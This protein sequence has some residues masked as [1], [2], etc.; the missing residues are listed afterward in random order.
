MF[1][2]T[3]QTQYGIWGAATHLSLINYTHFLSVMTG[4]GSICIYIYIYTHKQHNISQFIHTQQ[5]HIIWNTTLSFVPVC[6]LFLYWTNLLFQK[7]RNQFVWHI[8]TTYQVSVDT[9]SLISN[10]KSQITLMSVYV[11]MHGICSG[12]AKNKNLLYSQCLKAQC[13]QSLDTNTTAAPAVMWKARRSFSWDKTTPRL[14]HSLSRSP[15][16]SCLAHPLVA[17]QRS[18]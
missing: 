12:G 10:T 18:S 16:R 2:D 3:R 17:K 1:T 6:V 7:V 5:H 9:I 8:H 14:S 13:P 4:C 11:W 15:S